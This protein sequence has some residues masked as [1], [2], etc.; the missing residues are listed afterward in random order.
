[1]AIWVAIAD[2]IPLVGALVGAVPAVIVAYF[3]SL[4]TGIGTTI[5]FAA[6]QQIENYVV[7]PRVMRQAVNV[8]AAAV[9]LAALV[10]ATLLGFVGALIAIPIAA[11]IKVIMQRTWIENQESA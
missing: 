2:L 6:Y 10:G 7:Q 5:F 4:G 3:D 8:S 9:L 11:S 1:L